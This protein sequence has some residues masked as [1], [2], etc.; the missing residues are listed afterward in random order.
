[1]I[2]ACRIALV[3]FLFLALTACGASERSTTNDST[4]G[5]SSNRIVVSELS[6]P[7]GGMT[8]YDLVNQ[9]KPQWLQ[10]QGAHSIQNEPEIKVYVDNARSA[11]GSIS[12]LKRINALNVASIEYF[13]PNEAQFRF[14]MGNSVG[15]IM[16]HM[17]KGS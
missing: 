3:L 8:A 6:S 16:V 11:T 15:A 10:K 5:A 4:A 1:M 2:Y 14:G 9:Y 13:S 7:V 12:A 17:K